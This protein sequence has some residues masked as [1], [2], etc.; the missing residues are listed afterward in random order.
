[1]GNESKQRPERRQQSREFIDKM[2]TERTEMLVLFCKVSG[3]EPYES[4]SVDDVDAEDLQA[5]CQILVDYIASGHF[6]LYERIAA[7]RERRQPVIDLAQSIYPRIAE[8]TDA[9][10]DFS[11][12]YEA[13]DENLLRE[14]LSDDLSVLGEQ[15]ANRI[16]LED[17]L[18]TAL[19]GTPVLVEAP[20]IN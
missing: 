4:R 6:S 9:A 16:E 20:A 12:K 3:T 18:I 19:L 8:T 13:L 11:E 15:L 14:S 1:M 17:R 7:G 5:F 2:L 10:V